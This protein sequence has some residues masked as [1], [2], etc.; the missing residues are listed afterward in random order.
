MVRFEG[1]TGLLKT[2]DLT[3][4]LVLAVN[5]STRSRQTLPWSFTGNGEQPFRVDLDPNPARFVQR[6]ASWPT[7]RPPMNNANQALA[8]KQQMLGDISG[9]TVLA[10]PVGQ[11]ALCSEKKLV[12][13]LNGARALSNMAPIR[14]DPVTGT[15]Y[16]DVASLPAA[17]REPQFIAGIADQEIRWVNEWVQGGYL[18]QT[19]Q[20]IESDCRIYSIQ[21]YLGTLQ[22]ISGTREGQGVSQ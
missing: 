9:D 10:K 20:Q 7:G 13:G 14:P 2:W 22:E 16:A 6:V 17:Q 19:N 12:Q 11:L 5:P 3:P 4:V 21:R 18:T 8:Y 1:G 15:I